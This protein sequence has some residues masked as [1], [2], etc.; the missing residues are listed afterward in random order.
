VDS[1]ARSLISPLIKVKYPGTR[2]LIPDVPP[3]VPAPTTM[4]Y[5]ENYL[6]YLIDVP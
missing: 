2:P 5:I 1:A 3:G 6:P 4:E